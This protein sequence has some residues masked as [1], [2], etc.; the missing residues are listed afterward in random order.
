MRRVPYDTAPSVGSV[1][2]CQTGLHGAK[3]RLVLLVEHKQLN[4]LCLS[5]YIF[6]GC[7]GVHGW[8]TTTFLMLGQSHKGKLAKENK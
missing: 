7:S 8:E 3:R 5:L 6:T 4:S 1:Q 2:L